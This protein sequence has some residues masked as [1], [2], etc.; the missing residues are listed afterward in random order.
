MSNK[1]LRYPVS[2][3]TNKVRAIANKISDRINETG[4]T[5]D[6]YIDS[7]KVEILSCLAFSDGTS[8]IS[9]SLGD[10]ASADILMPK[11]EYEIY[12]RLMEIRYYLWTR[13]WD[14][15]LDDRFTYDYDEFMSDY[16]YPLKLSVNEEKED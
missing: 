15:L 7:H 9:V 2:L 6:K 3:D 5:A 12:A 10:R 14:E 4:L 8:L 11:N 16:L 13:N 1:K